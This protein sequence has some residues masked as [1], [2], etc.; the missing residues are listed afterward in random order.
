MKHLYSLLMLILCIQ[1]SAQDSTHLT[2]H[3]I[4]GS[5]PLA[6]GE[7]KWFGG[8]LGGHIGLQVGRDK[9]IHF[10]PNGK[11]RVFGHSDEP[12][13]Y[14]LS[15][16]KSFYNTFH[17]DSAKTMQVVISVSPEAKQHLDSICRGFL[18]ASPYPYAFFGM[19]CTSAC[20][21]LL[22]EAGV[23]PKMSKS[24][25]TRRFFY[26]RRLRKLLLKKATSQHWTIT[27]TAGTSCRKWDH[28]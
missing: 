1:V 27:Q 24:H 3:I 10:N 12:G 15:S 14:V 28:D 22:S 26:P 6:K 20:Y 16:K 23:V 5:K 17:C 18:N 2:V 8:K 4:Y 7:S 13:Q 19:R 11:V 25:M 21:H 9:I